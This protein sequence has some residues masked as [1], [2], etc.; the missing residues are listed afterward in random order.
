MSIEDRAKDV[1]GQL[2]NNDGVVRSDSQSPTAVV[3]L[4][5]KCKEFRENPTPSFQEL[6]APNT[7][8]ASTSIKVEELKAEIEAESAQMFAR[9][10]D[11]SSTDSSVSG[12]N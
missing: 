11:N 9:S 3:T 2:P 7:T 8:L 4:Q 5:E 12:A 1:Q 10:K 6:E